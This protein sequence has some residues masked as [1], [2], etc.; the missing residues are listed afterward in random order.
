MEAS[1]RGHVQVVKLLIA[2]GGKD[3]VVK[4]KDKVY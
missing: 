4:D 2:P 1:S 3:I